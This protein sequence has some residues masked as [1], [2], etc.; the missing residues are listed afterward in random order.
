M[1]TSQSLYV[2]SERLSNVTVVV[3]IEGVVQV[4]VL[5]VQLQLYDI[6][7]ELVSDSLESNM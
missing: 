7:N 6:G 4:D 2:P 5:D 1:A 3:E